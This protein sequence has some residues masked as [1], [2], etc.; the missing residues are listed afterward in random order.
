MLRQNVRGVGI[1][2][3]I[4]ALHGQIAVLNA[5]RHRGGEIVGR[6]EL[7][8]SLL[9]EDRVIARMIIEIRDERVE[10]DAVEQF[11]GVAFRIRDHPPQLLDQQEVRPIL[12]PLR[13]LHPRAAE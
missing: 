8:L 12:S 3:L 4:A 1:A 2:A 11:S 13:W 10:A 9:R 5:H 6:R 7:P